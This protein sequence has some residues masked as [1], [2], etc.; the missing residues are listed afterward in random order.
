[1]KMLRERNL[2]MKMDEIIG[3]PLRAAVEN[4]EA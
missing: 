2:W 1:M 3:V 4:E